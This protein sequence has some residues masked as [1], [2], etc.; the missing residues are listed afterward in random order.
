MK[1]QRN[2]NVKSVFGGIG[3]AA[4]LCVLMVLMSWSA[5]VTNSDINSE[6]TVATDSADTKIDSMDKIDAETQDNSY[7][8]NTF[9]FDDDREM[10]GMRTENTK[11]YLDDQG[12]MQMVVS[13]KPLHYTNYLGQLVDLDT[14]I[15][16]WDNGYYVSDIHNPVAFGHHA[17]QGFTMVLDDMEIVSGLDPVPVIVMQGQ[18]QE[19]QLPGIMGEPTNVI[20]EIGIEYFTPSSKNIEVGGSSIQYPLAHGM[21]LAY[22]VET[23]KVKQDLIINEL[24][25]ELK[26]HMQ[27]ST[28]FANEDMYA[29]SMFGLMESMV[30]PEN[31]ELWAGNQQITALDGVFAYD[32]MLTIR[33][34]T[35]GNLVAYIDA[36]VARDSS[37]VDK[38]DETTEVSTK[39]NT[40]YFIRMAED[41]Q[42]LEIITAVSTEWLLDDYTVF[43]VYIDPSVGSNT[44]TT[45]TT[46]VPSTSTSAGGYFTCV[47][48]DVDCFTQSNLSLIHI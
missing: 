39:P 1:E 4:L 29:F 42:S 2:R 24:S 30:L 8:V 45:L 27:S 21:D 22:H 33:D 34:A 23:N 47:I 43:P 11:T 26:L 9:G 37:T 38:I 5:M 12:K 6:S 19:L 7:E 13:H 20:H 36:P 32:S 10:L 16:T 44:E 14:S 15:K 41:G 40:Q 25:P 31:T 28:D 18:S 35:S 17:H 46:G 48:A 3:I